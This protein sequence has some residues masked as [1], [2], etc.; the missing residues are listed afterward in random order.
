MSVHRLDQ[1]AAPRGDL[2]ARAFGVGVDALRGLSPAER[3][4]RLRDRFESEM[5]YVS[6]VHEM[7]DAPPFRD[8][9]AMGRDAL[10]LLFDDLRRRDAPWTAW[11]IALRKILNDGPEIP[12]DEAGARDRVL[13]R[14]E[15]WRKRPT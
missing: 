2:T 12:D 4:H 15:A 1:D 14:W 11:V 13:A 7:L 6:S 3:F 5:A 8:I 10:P 9:V